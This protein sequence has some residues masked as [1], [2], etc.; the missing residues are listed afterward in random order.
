MATMTNPVRLA[1]VFSFGSLCLWI[2]AI[3]TPHWRR[4]LTPDPEQYRTPNQE[5]H[6]RDDLQR[7]MG[8]DK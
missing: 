8:S 5:A 3:A 2:A 6:V 7:Q 1:A 4:Y